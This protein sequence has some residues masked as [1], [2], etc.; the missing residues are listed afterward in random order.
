MLHHIQIGQHGISDAACV[1]NLCIRKIYTFRCTYTH[2]NIS[3]EGQALIFLYIFHGTRHSINI[4]IA[5][6]RSLWF[7]TKKCLQRWKHCGKSL[8]WWHERAQLY[9][10]LSKLSGSGTCNKVLL[11]PGIR[12]LLWIVRVLIG[13]SL[14]ALPTLYIQHLNLTGS[15]VV[16]FSM[17]G[18]STV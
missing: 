8:D 7:H 18:L 12:F 4:C 5:T 6:Q 15:Q 17:E 9:S 11:F 16:L 3:F 10:W 13:S 14:T 2:I 1:V